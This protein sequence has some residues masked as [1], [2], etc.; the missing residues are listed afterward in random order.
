MPRSTPKRQAGANPQSRGACDAM[1]AGCPATQHHAQPVPFIRA[2][3]QDAL[4]PVDQRQ[5]PQPS[6]TSLDVC[7]EVGL[8]VNHDDIEVQTIDD[9][10]GWW[11]D[12]LAKRRRF[13]PIEPDRRLAALAQFPR[14][15]AAR[16]HAQV[17]DC[18]S[19]DA[20]LV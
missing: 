17:T 10:G 5:C 19:Q 11:L 9:Y 1:E 6:L 2:V 15:V 18:T 3:P 16:V 7:I 20:A 13:R 12:R 14:T 8:G 4:G